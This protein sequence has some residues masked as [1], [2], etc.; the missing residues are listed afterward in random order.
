MRRVFSDVLETPLD[1][2]QPQSNPDTVESWDSINHLNLVM[3]IEQEFG[4]E[5]DPEEIEQM[6][7]VELTLK[8]LNGKLALDQR[9]NG[10]GR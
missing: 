2:I 1:E 9:L 8:I 3:A 4:I 5:L 7:S 10:G 6:M